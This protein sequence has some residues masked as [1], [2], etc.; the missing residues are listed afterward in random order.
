MK[1]ATKNGEVKVGVQHKDTT[2]SWGAKRKTTE[3]KVTLP[4]GE[5]L[6]TSTTCHGADKFTKRTGRRV[7]FLKL[8]D[9]DDAQAIQRAEKVW[10]AMQ[11]NDSLKATKGQTPSLWQDAKKYYKLS[12]EDRTSLAKIVCPEF[13]Q[14][15]PERKKQRDLSLLSNLLKKYPPKK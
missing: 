5:E 10:R 6:T 9:M 4:N 12:R 14:A 2:L 13:F 7:V 11:D 3:L 8:L 1:F 15:A